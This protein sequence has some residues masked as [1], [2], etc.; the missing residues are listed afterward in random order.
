MRTSLIALTALFSLPAFVS[1][2]NV[3]P[4]PF[5]VAVTHPFY[6]EWVERVGGDQVDAVVVSEGSSDGL[7]KADFVYETGL[8]AEPWL[9]AAVSAINPKVERYVLTDGMPTLERGAAFWTEM[10]PPH[11][12][13]ERLP[14]CCRK[15][16]VESNAAWSEL[17]KNIPMPENL[18]ALGVEPEAID[19][20]V[21][22]SVPN[23]MTAVVSI[24]ETLAEMDPEH[25]DTY[26]RNTALYLEELT[27]L[28]GWVKS[29]IRE[30]PAGKRVLVTD[31]NR[32]RY[33]ARAYGLVSP[34]Y[35]PAYQGIAFVEQMPG[36]SCALQEE[37]VYTLALPGGDKSIPYAEL[38]R[39]NTLVIAEALEHAE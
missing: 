16:A 19:P 33:F 30:V 4:E 7:A 11:S 23:A 25:A 34:I 10:D 38:M 20:N 9:D 22:F 27:G 24:N 21:W 26:D 1:A 18:E 17:V 32:F 37:D 39:G 3:K 12:N 8:D 6:A 31:G 14:P 36:K 28:D 29:E 13:P 15:D 5:K 35:S 2:V